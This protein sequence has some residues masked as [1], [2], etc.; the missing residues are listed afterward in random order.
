M[1]DGVSPFL[2]LYGREMTHIAARG[3]A[4]KLFLEGGY[5]ECD[6]DL[7]K[8]VRQVQLMVAEVATAGRPTIRS[9]VAIWSSLRKDRLF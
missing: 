6:E 9:A 2:L 8:D 7:D 5:Q 3:A 1:A 4:A